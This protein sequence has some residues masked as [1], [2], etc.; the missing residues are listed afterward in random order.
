MRSETLIG[1]SV[2][3]LSGVFLGRH[4]RGAI[5]TKVALLVVCTCAAV[6]WFLFALQ[7]RPSFFFDHGLR[8]WYG[9]AITQAL[10]LFSAFFLLPL[11]I[12]W[13]NLP[14][15]FG[16]AAA[17]LGAA[18]LYGVHVL[19]ADDIGT[20]NGMPSAIFD[21]VFWVLSASFWLIVGFAAASRRNRTAT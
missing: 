20:Y 17:F 11:V 19:G 13:S 16:V 7:P 5:R 18:I 1:A 12:P 2:L 6:G 9:P 10:Y 14:L 8:G 4:W 15:R 21:H 3:L